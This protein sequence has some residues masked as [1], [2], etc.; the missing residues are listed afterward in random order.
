MR[1]IGLALSVIAA[2]AAFGTSTAAAT[3]ASP[4]DLAKQRLVAVNCQALGGTPTLFNLGVDCEY[5]ANL[6][7][8]RQV[9]AGAVCGAVGWNISF[10][11]AYAKTLSISFPS[12]YICK[13]YGSPPVETI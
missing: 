3:T 1:K 10:I 4:L 9:L 11:S 2:T 5:V 13:L 12:G 8:S 6:N 7:F